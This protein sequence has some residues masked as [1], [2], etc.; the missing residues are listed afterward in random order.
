MNT[1]ELFKA[2]TII[3]VAIMQLTQYID[4]TQ[5]N[6]SQSW[7]SRKSRFGSVSVPEKNLFRSSGLLFYYSI[8]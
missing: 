7:V 3:A 1:Y 2:R 5:S 6:R 8:Y 4:K